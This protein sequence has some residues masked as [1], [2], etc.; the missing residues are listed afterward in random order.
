M[1]RI[2]LKDVSIMVV[3]CLVFVFSALNRTVEAENLPVLSTLS[4]SPGSLKEPFNPYKTDYNAAV[5]AFS[6][7]VTA[8]P[9]DPKCTVYVDG[10]TL[11]GNYVSSPISLQMGTTKTIKIEVV[12]EN[13]FNDYYIAVTSKN[14]IFLSSLSINEAALSPDFNKTTTN[15]TAYTNASSISITAVP[16][17]NNATVI[18]NGEKL[19]SNTSMPINI[20]NGETK[21]IVIQV[22]SPSNGGNTNYWIDVSQGESKV[23][24]E[25]DSAINIR[26]RSAILNAHINA[27]NYKDVEWYGFSYS[28]DQKDWNL[29]SVAG[30]KFTG[31]YSKVLKNL[32]SNTVYYYRAFMYNSHDYYTYGSTLSFSTPFTDNGIEQPAINPF[33]GTYSTSQVISIS[34]LDSAYIAFY[35]TD[36]TDPTISSS[37]IKY[38]SP[39][40]IKDS[41]EIK[42]AVYD[43]NNNRWSPVTSATFTFGGGSLTPYKLFWDVPSSHWAYNNIKYIV[44]QGYMTGYPDSSFGPGSGIKRA[45][46]A[47]IMTKLINIATYDTSTQHFSDVKPGD[48]YYASVEKAYQQGIVSGRGELFYP[49]QEMSREE[50]ARVLVISLG[51]QN[52][53]QANMNKKTE[54]NDDALISPSCRGYVVTAVEYGLIAGYNNEFNPQ[55]SVTRAEVCCMLTNFLNRYR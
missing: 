28:K 29:V 54:F 31:P 12:S 42:A 47:E 41:M 16:E 37:A 39:L 33:G 20:S 13:T 32:E 50:L 45:E 40:M 30:G 53:A 11:T 48:W 15:Y 25:T 4:L 27:N 6:I 26:S 8:I 17:E 35:T 22:S 23:V 43:A 9:V 14:N 55:N 24:I 10:Q 36:G 52:E 49:E 38:R 44:T 2:R 3:L 5:N 21:R 34:Y 19:N 18:V 46:V 51:K 1:H 7:T